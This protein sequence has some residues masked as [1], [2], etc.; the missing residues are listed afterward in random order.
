MKTILSLINILTLCYSLFAQQIISPSE[1]VQV[2]PV[3]AI[4]PTNTNNLIAAFSSNK[5]AT[6]DDTVRFK[7]ISCYRSFD[8]G[9][10]WSGIENISGKGGADP[11]VAFDP[12]E[13][14]YLLYQK[15][16]QGGLYLKKSY[17]GILKCIVTLLKPPGMP[18]A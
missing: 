16:E 4:N 15:R 9:Q 11:V 2:E 10:S 8:R 12:F 18:G 14:A 17:D 1:L 7:Q 5:E 3:I 6:E 13:V